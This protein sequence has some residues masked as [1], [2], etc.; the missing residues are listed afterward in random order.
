MVIGTMAWVADCWNRHQ[1]GSRMGFAGARFPTWRNLG[2]WR[3]LHVYLMYQ[4]YVCIMRKLELE[5]LPHGSQTSHKNQQQEEY[6]STLESGNHGALPCLS[7]PKSWSELVGH[8]KNGR[9]APKAFIRNPPPPCPDKREGVKNISPPLLFWSRDTSHASKGK[10]ETLNKLNW[11]KK[12]N[13]RSINTDQ[14]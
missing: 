12:E 14:D 8:S 3:S 6:S 11:S 1:E 4:W 10:K 7:C 13:D 2:A 5:L 9:S